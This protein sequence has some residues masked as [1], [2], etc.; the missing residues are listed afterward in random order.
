VIPRISDARHAGE[1]RVWLCFADGLMGK[2]NL[3]RELW[4]A[5]F[6]PLKDLAEFAK[7]RFEPDLDKIAWPNGADFAPEFLNDELKAALAAFSV[8]E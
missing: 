5:A 4:G 2:I 3:E 1:Y 8:A 7:V 6:E